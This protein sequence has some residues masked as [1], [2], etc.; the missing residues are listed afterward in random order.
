[1]FI[2]PKES[3]ENN[4][5]KTSN[6]HKIKSDCTFVLKSHLNKVKGLNIKFYFKLGFFFYNKFPFTLF[7]SNK[8]QKKEQIVYFF[9]QIKPSKLDYLLLKTVIVAGEYKKMIKFF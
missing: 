4:H 7:L 2:K 3:E 8:I 5:Q 9:W 6:K 1:M